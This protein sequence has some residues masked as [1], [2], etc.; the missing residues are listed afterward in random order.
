MISLSLR[1][2]SIS[3]MQLRFQYGILPASAA[4]NIA[5]EEDQDCLNQD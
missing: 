3:R 4:G 2:C 5:S 1:T